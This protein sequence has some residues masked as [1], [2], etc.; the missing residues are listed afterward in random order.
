MTRAQVRKIIELHSRHDNLH[1]DEHKD[2]EN[3]IV[4]ILKKEEKR[5]CADCDHMDEVHCEDVTT[6]KLHCLGGPVANCDCRG[7]KKP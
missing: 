5:R 2:L 1:P 3:A 4:R 7:F 6:G